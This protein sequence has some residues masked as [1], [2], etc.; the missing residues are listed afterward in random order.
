[1]AADNSASVV[2][3]LSLLASYFVAAVEGDEEYL[4]NPS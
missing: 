1:M 3:F 4:S 2:Y